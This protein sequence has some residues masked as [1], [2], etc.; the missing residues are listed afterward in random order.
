VP[1]RGFPRSGSA[2]EERKRCEKKKE[3]EGIDKVLPVGE[4]KIEKRKIK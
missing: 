1:A 4:K 3:G 2:R